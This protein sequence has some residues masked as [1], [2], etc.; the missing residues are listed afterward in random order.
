[1][2]GQLTIMVAAATFWAKE[3]K[4]RMTVS[5]VNV[6]IANFNAYMPQLA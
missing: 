5:I 1:V 3:N 2:K 4:I 6:F